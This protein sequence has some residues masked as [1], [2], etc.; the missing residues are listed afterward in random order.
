[1]ANSYVLY[2]GQTGAVTDYAVSFDYLSRDFV[3]AH[4]D[5][6][7][8]P[9]TF[10]SDTI[11]RFT[12]APVGDLKI[13]RETPTTPLNEFSDGAVLRG[14]DLNQS[15]KQP[16]HIVEETIDNSLRNATDGAWD[17]AN[18]R[19]KNVSDPVNDQDAVTKKWAVDAGLVPDE[20]MAGY[21]AGAIAAQAAAE[22]AVVDAQA[23]VVLAAAEKTGAQ[24]AKTAAEAAKTA[25]EAARDAALATGK[26]YPDT[27][28][29]LAGVLEGEYFLVPSGDTSES[30]ILYRDVAGVATEIKRFPS[31]AAVADL[32]ERLP[33]GAPSGY[34]GGFGDDTGQF[35]LLVKPDGTIEIHTL[36]ISDD[37]TAPAYGTEN[38]VQSDEYPYGYVWAIV[39]QYGQSPIGVKD[40]GTVTIKEIADLAAINGVAVADYLSGGGGASAEALGT[41]TAEINHIIG[42]GQSGGAGAGGVPVISTVQNFDSLMFVGGVRPYD[43]GGDPGVIYASL[44]PLVENQADFQTGETMMAGMTQMIKERIL[45]ENGI[46]Y[47]DQSYQML[48]SNHASGGSPID[49]LDEGTTPFA[50]CKQSIDYGYARAVALGKVYKWRG[51]T[52]S[53]GESDYN[54]AMSGATYKSKMQALRTALDTY[55]KSVTGQTDD[56]ICF[57][58]QL[59]DHLQYDTTGT[60]YIALTQLETCISD[61][62]FVMSCTN[63]S[64]EFGEPHRSATGHKWIGAYHGLAYKRTVIDGEKFMPLRPISLFRQGAICTVRFHVPVGELV[65]DIA[66]FGVQTNYGFSMINSVGG[67]INITSVEVIEKDVVKI[68]ADAPIGAGAKLR[69]AFG[70]AGNLRDQQGDSIVFDPTGINKPMHNWCVIFEESIP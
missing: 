8:A 45:A 24:T 49:G 47:T 52:W 32:T 59:A 35:S 26:V 17:A 18:S 10:L 2:P 69:Y 38:T 70:A 62:N 63:Y 30:F 46:A 14:V 44:V 11:I 29:G 25:A 68:V 33:S 23:E 5:G 65:I 15:N 16:V 48:A 51:Y 40:D 36:E 13:Y 60:R 28:A 67:A 31:T 21:H 64:I 39:D 6:V 50:Y 37:I 20:I 54:G 3:K 43:G 61:P 42:Y 41:F 7:A 22:A 1:M 56:A 66:S 57:V 58:D 27:T 53:Q 34:V 4:V 9:F 19:I 12:T 55:A